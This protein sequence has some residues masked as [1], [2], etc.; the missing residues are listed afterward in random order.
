MQVI[1]ISKEKSSMPSETA[2]LVR[3]FDEYKEAI[4]VKPEHVLGFIILVIVVELV[5][6]HMAI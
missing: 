1:L 4:Q 6:K 3:Y 2:G 5:L